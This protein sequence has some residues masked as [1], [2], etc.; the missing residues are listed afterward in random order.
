M[1]PDVVFLMVAELFGL[2]FHCDGQSF[3]NAVEFGTVN[4]FDIT[5]A[6]GIVASRQ[7]PGVLWT[8]NDSGYAGS[9]FALSTNGTLLGRYYLPTVFF[10]NFEDIAIGPGGT[11]EHQY[12]YLGDLGDNL[13]TR[14]S[15]RVFR[16]PEPA[17][18][19][20]FSNSPPILPL[21]AAQEIELKYPD[22]P[23]DA[24]ALMVD[25]LTGDLFISTKETNSARI[26]RASRAELDGGGPVVMSFIR[27]MAFSGFR[28][29]SAG[30]ISEDGRLIV[31]RRNGRAWVW[32]RQLSQ[33]VGA[34]LA[35]SGS[36]Q[37]VAE[38][39]NG[40]AIGFHA[41][42]LGYFTI[43]EGFQQPVN[44][45]RRTGSGI[46]REPIMF[47]PP[48]SQWRYQDEGVDEG[49]AWRQTAFDDSAWASG[50]AQL[51]YG[52]G[53]ERTV[54][55]YGFDDFEKNTTTYFRKQFTRTAG[56]TFTNLALRIC[57]T[58]GAEVY[59]NGT[60]VF[61]RNL[62]AN[63]GFNQVA[64]GSNSERQNYWLSVPVNPAL[65]K[66][67]ANTLAVELHRHELWLPDLS[68]DAQLVEAS[69]D[70]PVRIN[71]VPYLSSGSWHIALSGPVGALAQIEASDDLQLWL[72]A[73]Q[74]VL[75]NGS[76]QFQENAGSGISQRFYR[77]KN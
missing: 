29:V 14:L 39:L 63:A 32:N 2:S 25:P 75:T 52:Q 68:F 40:E 42:G 34:A 37:P 56:Q 4:T 48:G 16:F 12:V 33:S 51:G 43:S 7:N 64:T 19:S 46:P 67:G 76:G 57:Y 31:M 13:G 38:D 60:E 55:S 77:L 23:F 30:D 26:Y 41:S 49:V 5:E 61:R 70:L 22:K 47:I 1:R 9:I 50:A 74:V 59:L 3:A 66:V 6:S 44:Y 69:V 20:Y 54:V 35:S 45:F 65:V 15:I 71:G 53:D 36:T 18:Y 73:G 27:E 28:S 8:H 10:G 21:V 11:P 62:A 72:P 24:E 17:L 58:D